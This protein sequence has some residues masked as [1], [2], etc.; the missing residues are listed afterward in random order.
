MSRKRQSLKTATPRETEIVSSGSQTG[1]RSAVSPS[2]SL[3]DMHLSELEE[4]CA[5]FVA[6]IS[7]LRS[8]AAV[9]EY[10]EEEVREYT[11]GNLYASLFH[12]KN[13]VGPALDEID[14]LVD[15]MPDDDEDHS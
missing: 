4:E 12:L 9:R 7:A 11:E 6:L 13:H 15:L 3:L 1:A 8:M 2:S 14:R 10:A 5:R